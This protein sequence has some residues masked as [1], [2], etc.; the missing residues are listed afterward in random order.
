MNHL[1]EL[2]KSKTE[3]IWV[4]PDHIV[5]MEVG[6]GTEDAGITLT[7]STGSIIEAIDS[8]KD[9]FKKLVSAV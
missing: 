2:K 3:R 5:K 7:L 1:I 4:N 9:I 6:T 8:P